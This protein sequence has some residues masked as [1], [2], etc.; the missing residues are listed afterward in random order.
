MANLTEKVVLIRNLPQIFIHED[1]VNQVESDERKFPYENKSF[2]SLNS[3]PFHPFQY[4]SGRIHSSSS[5]R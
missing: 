2:L 3:V 4:F 1:R 5:R